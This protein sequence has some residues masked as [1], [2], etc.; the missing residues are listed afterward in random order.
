MN[1]LGIQ[2]F[3]FYNESVGSPKQ[4]NFY[5]EKAM[6][7]NIDPHIYHNEYRPVPPKDG[8]V[9]FCF[10][11][12]ELFLKPDHT[13][14]RVSDLPDTHGLYWLFCIDDTQYYLSEDIPED[15]IRENIRVLRGFEPHHTGFAAITAWQ[16][17]V[18]RNENRY[19]G[20]CGHP[21]KEDGKE[22]AMRCPDCGHIVYPRINP[23]V[24]VGVLN[25]K[26]QLLVT[27]YAN[28]SY[29]RYALI[30]GFNEV[31]ETIE[32]TVIREVKE[33]AGLNVRDLRYYKCQPW[34]FSSTLLFGFWCR[35]DGDDTIRI[36]ENELKIGR[37]ADRS[38][39]EIDPKD[40]AALTA[41][42]I[43]MFL[44]GEAY[45]GQ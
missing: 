41:E 24:I 9:V 17:Y 5:L 6:I 12:N 38:E 26:G 7:Q 36:D 1:S 43:R 4:G 35:V 37:W 14:Y 13:V 16:L 40:Q 2:K 20:K 32:E 19:C 22:R 31:G 23:A 45:D 15:S 8:D 11:G 27:K 39:D 29:N 10:E 18:W 33:E 28:S 42:M 44:R 30:A 3:L 21:M 25:D 34:S